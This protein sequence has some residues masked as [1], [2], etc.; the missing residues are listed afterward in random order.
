[1]LIYIEWSCALLTCV[2]QFQ[3]YDIICQFICVCIVYILNK[4]NYIHI[5]VH[6]HVQY[7]YTWSS[8]CQL[9]H[10]VP[11]TLVRHLAIVG[12]QGHPPSLVRSWDQ[13]T[14]WGARVILIIE[15]GGVTNKKRG[16]NRVE[17]VII[18]GDVWMCQKMG[19]LPP[20]CFFNGEHD[21]QPWFKP[22]DLG[23]PY[24]QTKPCM[25]VFCIWESWQPGFRRQNAWEVIVATCLTCSSLLQSVLLPRGEAQKVVRETKD[26]NCQENYDTIL[27]YGCVWKCCISRRYV[28]FSNKLY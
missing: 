6:I 25:R 20:T 11:N 14:A 1:M 8:K 15:H 4:N 3:Y 10:F 18:W 16:F 27:P 2:I 9:F 23:V 21:D 5:H 22:V 26:L 13:A 12:D 17:W 19:S 7:V 28:G 24:F